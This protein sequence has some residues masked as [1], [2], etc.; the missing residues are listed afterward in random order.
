MAEIT[1]DELQRYIETDG[2]NCPFCASED[3]YLGQLRG[4]T[5]IVFRDITCRACQETWRE[6]FHL[7]EVQYPARE[8][9]SKVERP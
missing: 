2:S 4:G 8:D 9:F 1:T 7:A 5:G 6:I 3:L